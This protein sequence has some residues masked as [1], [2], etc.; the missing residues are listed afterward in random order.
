VGTLSTSAARGPPALARSR[1]RRR[2]SS[3]AAAL[4]PRT[5]SAARARALADAAQAVYDRRG[6][7]AEDDVAHLRARH[8]QHQRRGGP[9]VA[10]E[11]DRTRSLGQVGDSVEPEL[12]VVEFLR[13]VVRLVLEDDGDEGHAESGR[14]LDLLDPNV[15]SHRFFD[16]ARHQLLDPARVDPRPRATGHRDLDGNVGVLPLRHPEVPEQ[17]EQDGGGQYHP[18]DMGVLREEA[19]RVVRVLD[20][21]VVGKVR[22]RTSAS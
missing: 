11:V 20:P 21:P 18:R 22:H 12:D 19:R 16:S 14:G 10:D 13:G 8:R 17:A 3:I 2:L 4:R 6:L 5:T 15:L 7:E 9:E 1:T